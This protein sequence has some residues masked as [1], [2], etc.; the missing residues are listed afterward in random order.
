MTL[1]IASKSGSDIWLIYWIRNQLDPGSSS[2]EEV[3]KFNWTKFAIYA[4]LALASAIFIFIRT[5]LLILG[6]LKLAH[7]LHKQMITLLI[8]APINLFHDVTPKG[9]ILNRLSKDLTNIDVFTMYTYNRYLTFMFQF[10]GCIVVCAYYSV[11]CLIIVPFILVFGV[12]FMR[13]YIKSSRELNRLDGV[14]RS[15]MLNLLAESISG[16]ITIR[17]Y[18]YEEFFIQKFSERLDNCHKVKIFLS[19]VSNWFGLYL[20]L[21]SFVFLAALVIYS[22]YFYK[23]L[24]PGIIGIILTYAISLQDNLS[25]LLNFYCNFENSMIGLERCLKYTTIPSE[26]PYELSSDD[27]IQNWPN[28]GN[29]RF[30]NYS[31]KY[32]PDTELVLK[33][34]TFS[35]PGGEKIGIVGR[36]GSGKSTICLSLFRILEPFTGT[37]FIDDVDICTLGLK[38]LR[39]NL[40]IIPQVK[41]CY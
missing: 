32:R 37:I 14:V 39:S 35:M 12:I 4:S 17:A 23:E 24:G 20:D 6:T 3:V 40:T 16:S 41:L 29:I 27:V 8:R 15:P 26:K 10:L 18:N 9:Q 13:F 33:G 1:W 28:A 22:I 25:K 36:T 31:V 38:K 21:L 11:Y 5:Y 34:L 7:N 30:E 19:G 2:K